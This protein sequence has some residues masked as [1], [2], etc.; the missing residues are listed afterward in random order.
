MYVR[1]HESQNLVSSSIVHRHEAR[2]SSQGIPLSHSATRQRGA[3]IP[4]RSPIEAR[5]CCAPRRPGLTPHPPASATIAI[6]S[7]ATDVFLA[8]LHRPNPVT[9]ASRHVITGFGRDIG[10]APQRRRPYT[11]WCTHHADTRIAVDPVRAPDSPYWVRR[12][13]SAAI[14]PATSGSA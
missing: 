8:I 2:L 6:L 12:I 9:H 13:E 7:M 14:G 4:A 10:T 3:D 11:D 5:P 1:V